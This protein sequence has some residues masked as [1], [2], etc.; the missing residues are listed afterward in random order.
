MPGKVI[1]KD[2]ISGQTAEANYEVEIL[3]AEGD[4]VCQAEGQEIGSVKRDMITGASGEEEGPGPSGSPQDK[5]DLL[6]CLCR[7]AKPERSDFDCSYNLTPYPMILGGSPS[8]GDLKNGPCMCQS[9]GCFRAPLPTSGECYNDCRNQ[10][11]GVPVVEP[12]QGIGS[13]TEGEGGPSEPESEEELPPGN[14]VPAGVLAFK[15]E[16]E[17]NSQIGDANEIEFAS[18]VGVKGRIT[19]ADDVDFFRFYVDS[20]GMLEV[21]IDQVPDQMKPRIDLYG[22]NF[23]WI[24]RKDASN[25][26]DKITLLV[27]LPGPGQGFIAILDLDRKAHPTDY[28]FVATFWPAGDAG[29]PNDRGGDSTE[30]GFDQEVKAYICPVGDIDFYE[31]YVDSAGIMEVKFDKVPGDMKPRID[32]YN[33]NLEWVTRKDASNTGD[34]L[35]MEVDLPGPEAHY[36][37]ISDLDRKAHS[38]PYSFQAAFRP[39]PDSNEPNNQVGDSTEISPGQTV[40]GYICPLND[41]DFYRLRVEAPTILEAKMDRVPDSMRARIDLYGKNFNWITRKD[42]SNAGD[43]ITLKSDLGGPGVYYLAISD[44]DRKAHDQEYQLTAVLGSG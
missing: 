22:K 38:D 42:A 17:P 23:N 7:C 41:V 24:T 25:Q 35:T 11:P 30:I 29:E 20:A 16:T 19:P 6:N 9:L 40:T 4:E 36:L 2:T 32:L 43:S 1:V 18:S 44:L 31:L 13:P 15:P 26:G 14:L 12:E 27:D 34:T 8:C 28:S 10:Y 21:K 3:A 33:K 5:L 39:A 37:A